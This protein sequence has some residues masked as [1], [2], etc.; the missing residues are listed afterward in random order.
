MKMV[1]GYFNAGSRSSKLFNLDY[2]IPASG[3]EKKKAN[4]ILVR[5]AV[6]A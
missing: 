6:K 2:G 4:W 3:R 1:M 5:V